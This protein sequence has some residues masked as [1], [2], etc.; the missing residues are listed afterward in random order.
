[1]RLIMHLLSDITVLRLRQNDIFF[2]TWPPPF[3]RDYVTNRV[4]SEILL[5]MNSEWIINR[6]FTY[7]YSLLHD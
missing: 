5:A 7:I 4:K 1:M 3:S 2:L 6:I